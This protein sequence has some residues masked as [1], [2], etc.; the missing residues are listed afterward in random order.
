MITLLV[1]L[2]GKTWQ[3][4]AIDPAWLEPGARELFWLDIEGPQDDER[5]ILEQI[6]HVH[7]LIVEDAL[8]EIHHPKIERYDN[9]LYLILHG[10]VADASKGRTGFATQDVDFIVGR[11]YLVTVHHEKSR[12]IE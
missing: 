4:P 2:D 11:N 12:S 10:I 6:L 5:Q 9:V 7:E 1:H 3:M 8:A